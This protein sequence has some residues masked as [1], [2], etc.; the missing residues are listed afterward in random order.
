MTFQNEMSNVI[1]GLKAKNIFNK[2][3]KFTDN[4]TLS[5]DGVHIHNLK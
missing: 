2:K 3:I 4:E 1:S 5:L